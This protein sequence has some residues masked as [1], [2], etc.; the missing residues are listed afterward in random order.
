M[1]KK[2]LEHCLESSLKMSQEMKTHFSREAKGKEDIRPFV[3]I[4]LEME[5][6]EGEKVIAG[7]IAPMELKDDEHPVDTL[8]KM[9]SELNKQGLEKFAWLCFITEGYARSAIDSNNAEEIEK[10]KNQERGALEK[11]FNE[12]ADTDIKEGIIATLFTWENESLVMTSF[13][14]WGDDGLPVY[15]EINNEIDLQRTAEMDGKVPFTFNAFI[16]YCQ[17]SEILNDED[18]EEGESKTMWSEKYDNSK[19][20]SFAE[21]WS[22]LTE[23]DDSRVS[24]K[25]REKVNDFNMRAFTVRVAR[26]CW[27]EIQEQIN[28]GELDEKEFTANTQAVMEGDDENAKMELVAQLVKKYSL[29]GNS[30]ALASGRQEMPNDISELLG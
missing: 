1:D 10:I 4:G 3:I 14:K 26:E 17:M 12:K 23:D 6:D 21:V 16:K 27:A 20:P 22:V 2:M 28:K 18:D 5:N 19:K 15:E 25:V 7:G 13:Y 30:I 24:K 8:P 11:E 29:L 9:L